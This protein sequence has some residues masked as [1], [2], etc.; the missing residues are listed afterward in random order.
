MRDLSGGSYAAVCFTSP[1]GV[2]AVATALRAAHLTARVFDE[3]IVAAVGPGT[4]TTLGDVLGVHPHLVPPVSTTA[5]LADAFPSGSGRVLLPRADIASPTLPERLRIKGYDP[6]NVIA[7]TTAPPERLP[8]EVAARLA[9]GDIDLLVFTSSSTVRNFS[10]LIA[11]RRWSGRVVSIGPVTSAT[12]AELGIE[13]CSEAERHDLDGVVAALVA[14]A[15]EGER[16]NGPESL[17]TAPEV[18]GP[19]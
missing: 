6:V 7:Y 11:G 15:R 13:V 4:A 9:A 1:N 8:S 16:R 12:C 2:R 19:H 14:V 10:K 5:A 3:V 17:T 18:G